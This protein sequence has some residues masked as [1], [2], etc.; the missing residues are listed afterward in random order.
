MIDSIAG[1]RDNK[2]F[3]CIEYIKIDEPIKLG[4]KIYENQNNDIEYKI[5]YLLFS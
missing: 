3:Y 2:N 1:I 5:I 4:I